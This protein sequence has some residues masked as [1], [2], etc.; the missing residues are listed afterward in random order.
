MTCEVPYDFLPNPPP[1]HSFHQTP[2]HR[3]SASTLLQKEP[4]QKPKW[5]FFTT[6]SH[7]GKDHHPLPPPPPLFPHSFFPKTTKTPAQPPQSNAVETPATIDKRVSILAKAGCTLINTTGPPCLPSEPHKFHRHLHR[8]FSSSSP[9][10][11]SNF[12]SG[13]ASYIHSPH[14]LRRSLFVSAFIS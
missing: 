7:P 6:K 13:F 1:H 9:D 3:S 12:L 4:V 11:R 2:P 14:N 5:C 8:L 10:I